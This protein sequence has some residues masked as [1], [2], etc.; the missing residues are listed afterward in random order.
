M[1]QRRVLLPCFLRR[2]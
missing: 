1:I 2:P